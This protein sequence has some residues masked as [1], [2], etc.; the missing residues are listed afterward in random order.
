MVSGG[1]LQKR[2]NIIE[3]EANVHLWPIISPM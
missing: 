2:E 3:K 1:K